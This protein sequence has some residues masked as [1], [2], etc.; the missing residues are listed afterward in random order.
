MENRYVAKFSGYRDKVARGFH[1]QAI[2]R[3]LGIDL[4]DYGPGWF[5]TQLTPSDRITQHHG[6]VHAGAISTMADLSSGFAA[7]S[8]MAEEEEVLTVEFKINL[9]R[10]ATGDQIFCH[11]EVIKPGRR[12]YFAESRVFSQAEEQEKLIA[13][14]MV[15]L[16]VVEP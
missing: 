9:L 6:Y 1:N 13:T 2:T 10:P 3:T 16:A 15:T 12:I 8:L 14:A 11:A 5:H 7:Y 4:I